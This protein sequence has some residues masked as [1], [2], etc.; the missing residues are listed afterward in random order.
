MRDRLGDVARLDVGRRVAIVDPFE[1][2]GGDLPAGLVHRRDR[3]AI[4]RHRGRDR[5]D[6]DRNRSAR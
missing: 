2:V 6:G 4:A 1:A 3:F 5:I